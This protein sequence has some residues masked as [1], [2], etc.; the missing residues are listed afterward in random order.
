MEHKESDPDRENQSNR[1]RQRDT[2]QESSSSTAEAEP[3]AS[4]HQVVGNQAVQRLHDGG[5]LQANLAVSQP[6]DPAER[7]AERVAEQVLNAAAEQRGTA[8][9]TCVEPPGGGRDRSTPPAVKPMENRAPWINASP[10]SGGTGGEQW[11]GEDVERALESSSGGKPLPPAARSFFE[12]LFGRDFGDVRVHTGGKA[13]DLNRQLDARAFTY[14]SDI[15][16]GEGQYRPGSAEGKRLMAHELTHVVQQ[17]SSDNIG[18][19]PVDTIQRDDERP[20]IADLRGRRL[21][22]LFE[23]WVRNDYQHMSVPPPAPARDKIKY[24]IRYKLDTKDRETLQWWLNNDPNVNH[25]NGYWL[26]EAIRHRRDKKGEDTGGD[27]TKE[28]PESTSGRQE[29]IPEG[30]APPS[31]KFESGDTVE[32]TSALTIRVGPGRGYQIAATARENEKGVVVSGPKKAGKYTWWEIEYETGDTGWSAQPWLEGISS[33]KE[34]PQQG[35][36]SLS[37]TETT[38]STSVDSTGNVVNEVSRLLVTEGYAP[39]FY[40]DTEGR[41]TIGIGRLIESVD[42]ARSLNMSCPN[43][44]ANESKASCIER[45]YNIVANDTP[46]NSEQ[47]N[48][49]HRWYKDLLEKTLK[50][51]DREECLKCRYTEEQA[52]ADAKIHVKKD[53]NNVRNRVP[54]FDSYPKEAKIA[55][56]RFTYGS[57]VAGLLD[58][59]ATRYPRFRKAILARNWSKCA[60]LVPSPPRPELRN[61]IVSL[62]EKAGGS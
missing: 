43:L 15:Y 25:A 35:D 3:V 1:D 23:L 50:S 49:T 24:V 41:V 45:Q 10:R 38:A 22:D 34:I 48:R 26:R 20:S 42:E 33:E 57:G 31:P 54:D 9:A 2:E 5:V 36:V 6:N 46:K 52:M 56:L 27:E 60:K 7:E 44:P 39:Y 58:K 8:S 37:D 12:P 40:Q 55:I 47:L 18:R 28:K 16:F 62:F 17:K 19:E 4:L 30:K 61:K 11:V 32:T 51:E 53:L 29:K 14:G 21:E 13:A 59:D